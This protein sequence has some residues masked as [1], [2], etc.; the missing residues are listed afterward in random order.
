MR[1]VI[2]LVIAFMQCGCV[3]GQVDPAVAIECE[4]PRTFYVV[5]HGWHTGIVV[6]GADLIKVVPALENEFTGPTDFL[7]IGWGDEQFY[8]AQNPTLGLAIRAILTPTPTVLHIVALPGGSQRLFPGR[9]VLEL[10]V[11]PQGYEK[12]L[13][14]I[15]ES[16][17]R[18]D[19]DSVISLEAG[20]YGDS[21][22]YRAKGE[23]HAFNTCNTWVARAIEQTGYPIGDAQV[24]TADA[25]L[26]R[27]R[28]GTGT[29]MQCFS[30]R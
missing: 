5:N 20:L 25:L 24:S 18:A 9:E 13:A 27:L 2:L 4:S 23:F 22:F 19:D 29:K 21:R 28:R 3:A 14:Y 1:A 30:V 8:R 11:P 16:F 17:D 6:T 26:S 15:A 7:E 10:T 12:L